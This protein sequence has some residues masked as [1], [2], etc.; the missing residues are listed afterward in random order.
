MQSVHEMAAAFSPSILPHDFNFC[1]YQA[2]IPAMTIQSKSTV[3]I[4]YMNLF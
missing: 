3:I 2:G 4:T 1:P